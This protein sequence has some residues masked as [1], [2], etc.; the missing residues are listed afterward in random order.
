MAAKQFEY[1]HKDIPMVKKDM[2]LRLIFCILFIGTFTWQLGNIIIAKYSNLLSKMEIVIGSVTLVMCL[3]YTVVAFVFAYQDIKII[4]NINKNG[5]S[6]RYVTL[7][8][9]SDKRSFIRLYTLISDIISVVM[10][11][12]LVSGV[13]YSV[14]HYVYFETVSYYL[15]LLV[16]LTLSGFNGVWHMNNEISLMKNVEEYRSIY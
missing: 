3:I 16:M 13:T 7:L 2:K 15:P 5:R 1:Q 12:V 6:V 8:S 9:A 4:R 11:L 14:L 10:L